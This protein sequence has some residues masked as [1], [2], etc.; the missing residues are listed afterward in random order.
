MEASYSF[1]VT[2]NHRPI[3]NPFE[4]YS[5][6]VSPEPSAAR[7]VQKETLSVQQGR[8][9][10]RGGV[11]TDGTGWGRQ[12]PSV[13]SHFLGCHRGHVQGHTCREAPLSFSFPISDIALK[14]EI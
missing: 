8:G 6:A 2:S 3:R 11:G 14:P 10:G 4:K 7:G 5:S 13:P 9:G 12:Q 1:K